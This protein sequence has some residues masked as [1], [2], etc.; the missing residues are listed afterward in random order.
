M[1]IYSFDCGN[2]TL[3]ISIIQWNTSWISNIIYKI[4]EFIIEINNINTIMSNIGEMT[5]NNLLNSL[6]SICNLNK[7]INDFLDD[8]IYQYL[9]Q[10]YIEFIDVVDLIPG[11]KVKDV[12]VIDR[13]IP[14]KN[15]IQKINKAFH[16][17]DIV[18]IEDQMSPNE[19]SRGVLYCLAYEYSNVVRLIHARHKNKVNFGAG[20]IRN[21]LIKYSS[22]ESA[23]KAH[24]EANFN[25]Y[26]TL[27]NRQD[28]LQIISYRHYIRKL[29]N[30]PIYIE[31]DDIIN[32]DDVNV[33]TNITNRIESIPSS[34]KNSI[35]IISKRDDMA[36]AFFQIV[37][38]TM[39][40]LR[41]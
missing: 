27:I 36:D 11:K 2:K 29:Y 16:N 15:Y 28:I 5:D 37:A 34:V 21:Y 41:I 40:M 32:C 26:L 20:D 7:R 30:D 33:T 24:T 6:Y 19:K 9:N 10:W 31:C 38:W 35:K 18:L 14:L 1:R 13:C 4:G 25:S 23:N 22:S 8:F 39:S 3:A 12:K 17:P